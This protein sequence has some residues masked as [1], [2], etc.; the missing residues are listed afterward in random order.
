MKR[1]V[2][3]CSHFLNQRGYIV[4]KINVPHLV[5]INGDGTMKKLP[6]GST[7]YVIKMPQGHEFTGLVKVNEPY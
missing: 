3:L 6:D 1:L 5:I 4:I 7:E 2:R